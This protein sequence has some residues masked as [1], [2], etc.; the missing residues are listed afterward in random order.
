MTKH[1]IVQIITRKIIYN[2]QRISNFSRSDGIV[3]IPVCDAH[4]HVGRVDNDFFG[5]T[6]CDV[7]VNTKVN[8]IGHS[9][10]GQVVLASHS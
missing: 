2:Y 5:E 6:S 4:S 3:A 9:L 8:L 1:K 7:S 10:I